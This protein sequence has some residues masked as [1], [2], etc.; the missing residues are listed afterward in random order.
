MEQVAHQAIVMQFILDLARTL[1]VDPRGCFR[2][3]FSKIK[4]CYKT[5][6]ATLSVLACSTGK[7]TT[8]FCLSG[9]GFSF[10]FSG[11]YLIEFQVSLITEQCMTTPPPAAGQHIKTTA[12]KKCSLCVLLYWQ[13]FSEKAESVRFVYI[14]GS[15]SVLWPKCDTS[16]CTRTVSCWHGVSGRAHVNSL[17]GSFCHAPLFAAVNGIFPV[18]I[19]QMKSWLSESIHRLALVHCRLIRD[20]INKIHINKRSV[21]RVIKWSSVPCS[22]GAQG[23][24]WKGLRS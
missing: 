17:I 20:Q 24:F 16:N 5:W 23:I 9:F 3:F 19:W 6:P 8:S 15:T 18:V 11:I 13:G 10:S 14:G 22:K 7:K 1:E 21:S 12:T 4:V 2:Q